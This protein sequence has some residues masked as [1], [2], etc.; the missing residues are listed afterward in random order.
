VDRLATDDE[1][2]L[3]YYRT[4]GYFRETPDP[5]ADL[6]DL[7]TGRKPGRQNPEERTMSLNL[8]LAI[9]DVATAR[10]IYERALSAGI[11]TDLPL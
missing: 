4:V 8:G 5:Y 11:G 1:G 10:L 6:G 3:S 9:E 2:Q 7:V